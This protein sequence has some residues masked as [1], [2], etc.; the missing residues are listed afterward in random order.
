MRRATTWD[1]RTYRTHEHMRNFGWGYLNFYSI[2][3]TYGT[4]D[5]VRC[6]NTWHT[7]TPGTLPA[8]FILHVTR[9]DFSHRRVA[10]FSQNQFLLQRDVRCRSDEVLPRDAKSQFIVG[11]I[12]VSQTI[13]KSQEFSVASR[14]VSIHT[15]FAFHARILL[16]LAVAL[17]HRKSQNEIFDFLKIFASIVWNFINSHWLW[18]VNLISVVN[19]CGLDNGGLWKF[20]DKWNSKNQWLN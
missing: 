15:F 9:N 6:A 20:A 8:W 11:A 4:H 17:S 12:V 3:W 1:R 7:R 13:S 2:C 19:N 5:E 18:Q 16:F 14:R 10:E